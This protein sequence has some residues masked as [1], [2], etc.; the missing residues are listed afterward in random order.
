MR[1]R[2][3][4]D[5]QE[6]VDDRDVVVEDLP[7]ETPHVSTKPTKPLYSEV[8]RIDCEVAD[9]MQLAEFLE[10]VARLLREDSSILLIV[11]KKV[12]RGFV[13]ETPKTQP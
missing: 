8:A 9:G 3:D 13:P 2:R 1:S 10:F 11:Q 4:P 12:P 5:R 7:V 6:T